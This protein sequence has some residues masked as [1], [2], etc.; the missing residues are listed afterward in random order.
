M[1][2]NIREE[3]KEIQWKRKKIYINIIKLI[4]NKLLTIK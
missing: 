3:E 2:K 4:N 1:R